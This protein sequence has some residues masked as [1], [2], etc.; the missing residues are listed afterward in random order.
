MW[1]EGFIIPSLANQS[2]SEKAEVEMFRYAV[3][4]FAAI[5]MGLVVS[6]QGQSPAP[7]DPNA[8]LTEAQVA[9]RRMAISA[10]RQINTAE[11]RTFSANKRY[12]PL[13]ELTGVSIPAG[14]AAQV[15]TDGTSYTFSVKDQEDGCKLAVFSDQ[16]GLIYTASPL[17]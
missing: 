9:R 11:A 10:A 4:V 6:P 12:A 13:S 2:R 1:S 8:P 15:S 7:C 5:V 16:S 17:R 3:A 14:F